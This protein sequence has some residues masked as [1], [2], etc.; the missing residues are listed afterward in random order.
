M[1]ANEQH[2]LL[3]PR[4]PADLEGSDYSHM[5]V[6]APY[7]T[8]NTDYPGPSMPSTPRD[9]SYADNAAPL[10]HQHPSQS[11]LRDSDMPA[12]KEVDLPLAAEGRYIRPPLYKRPLFWL[13]AFAVL[14]IVVLAVILPVY[15]VVI[16]PRDDNTTTSGSKSGTKGGAPADLQTTG[17]NGSTIYTNGTTFTYV[18]PFGGFCE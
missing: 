6:T 18:N 13:G 11:A 12:S 3:Y 15:F 14:A 17:G 5:P 9:S 16:K 1:A 10:L 4:S 2:S 7:M 8:S